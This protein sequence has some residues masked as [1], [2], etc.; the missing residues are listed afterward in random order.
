MAAVAVALV[1]GKLGAD[2]PAL[3]PLDVFVTLGGY[4]DRF[5]T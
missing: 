4:G 5:W 3:E 1:L 2:F